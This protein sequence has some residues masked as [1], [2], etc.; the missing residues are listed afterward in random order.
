V[1]S[2]S[3]FQAATHRLSGIACGL[4]EGESDPYDAAM[5]LLACSKDLSDL[6]A[7]SGDTVR[8]LLDEIA[9]LVDEDEGSCR[10]SEIP[11]AV[12]S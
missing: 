11:N 7:R 4:D 6:V 2:R 5:Q 8:F 1:A 12:P 10:S 3:G 9:D